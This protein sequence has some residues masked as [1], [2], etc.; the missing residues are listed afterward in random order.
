M[1]KETD[2]LWHS[3]GF[4]DLKEHFGAPG[5]ILRV[6]AGVILF[7]KNPNS[8]IVALG[9]K[10]QLSHMP[11]ARPL[12]EIMKREL[13]GSGV[14]EEKILEEAES[15]GTYEALKALIK[16]AKGIS[17]DEIVIVSNRYH[18]PRIEAM[19]A[20]EPVLKDAAKKFK[21]KFASAEDILIEN[22][23]KAW[24]G[25]LKTI[26]DSAEI[27]ELMKKEEF[28]ARQVRE[29]KYKYPVKFSL[30]KAEL[31]DLKFLF[32]L[33]NEESVKKVSLNS[34]PIDFDAH[35]KWFEKKLAV[36][37]NVI[38][39]AEI[40]SLPIVQ[41]VAQTRFDLDGNSAEVNIAVVAGFRGKGYGTEI[42]K[43]AAA[44]FFKEFP[45]T[46]TVRAFINL[47]NDASLKSFTKA[48]YKYI[49]KS[50]EGGLMRHLMIL[51]N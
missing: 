40:D 37:D 15:S 39:I 45:E 9:G 5:S 49:G 24:E 4:D 2:G 27:K 19:V 31:T 35:S 34:A 3:T 16:I 23:S 18:L 48:G 13:V 12:A 11:D 7:K 33:R 1:K 20:Y 28:G 46:K 38:F 8:F 47:G 26:Y 25:I 43:T 6:E 50:E 42:L 22:N 36:S 10:G 29:G 30:R 21:I 44:R 41:P 17:P 14:P 51:E 32:N